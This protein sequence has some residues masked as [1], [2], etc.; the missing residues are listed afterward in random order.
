M[1]LY[2][3]LEIP[4]HRQPTSSKI[5]N[6]VPAHRRRR[7]LAKDSF[8]GLEIFAQRNAENVIR[9]VLYLIGRLLVTNLATT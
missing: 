6:V 9:Y 7:Y 5:D 8:A 4:K 2:G 1:E 3:T